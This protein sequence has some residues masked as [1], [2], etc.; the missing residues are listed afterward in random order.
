MGATVSQ[1]AHAFTVTTLMLHWR[2]QLTLRTHQQVPK[3]KQGLSSTS[4]VL[5]TITSASSCPQT[6]VLHGQI[7]L[8]VH[9]LQHP[10]VVLGL[11][12]SQEAVTHYQ[13][14]QLC[15]MIQEVSLP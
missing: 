10:P 7:F 11:V 4:R 8:L 5:H 12:L 1:A 2:V 3:F 15:L 14:E 6:M 9:P 13:M